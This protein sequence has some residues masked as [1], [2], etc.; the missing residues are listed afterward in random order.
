M[1]TNILSREH[2]EN[3]DSTEIWDLPENL[4]IMDSEDDSPIDNA[5]HTRCITPI[6]SVASSNKRRSLE[7]S[8]NGGVIVSPFQ[9]QSQ[10]SN[11][12]VRHQSSSSA[13]SSAPGT[14]SQV[15]LM[16]QL[17]ANW[18][19]FEIKS[20]LSRI[21]ELDNCDEDFQ[22]QATP[23]KARSI[24][25]FN[26]GTQT[27][28]G[29]TLGEGNHVCK[30]Q[31]V[32][33]V[34]L[35]EEVTFLDTSQEP[36]AGG[37][38][39]LPHVA[40]H[41]T[42]SKW[43][44]RMQNVRIDSLHDWSTDSAYM[45]IPHYMF[46][47]SGLHKTVVKG[48]D[49]VLFNR[50]ACK[51]QIKF[52]MESVIEI[53]HNGFIRGQPGTGKSTTTFFTVCP[54]RFEYDIVWI[55]MGTDGWVHVVTMQEDIMRK[56]E[57]RGDDFAFC[58]N[59]DVLDDPHRRTRKIILVLDSFN[60]ANDKH[61]QHVCEGEKWRAKDSSNRR[62]IAVSSMAKSARKDCMI[63]RGFEWHGVGSWKLEEYI[64]A[65]Q[66]IEIW[67]SVKGYFAEPRLVVG[68]VSDQEGIIAMTPV[69]LV[70]AKFYYAG[71][72]ARYMFGSTVAEIVLTLTNLIRALSSTTKKN[73]LSGAIHSTKFKH[74]CM[75]FT[76]ASPTDFTLTGFVSQFVARTLG[77]LCR[78]RDIR[79]LGEMCHL[80]PQARGWMFEAFFLA[81]V[82]GSDRI[83]VREL[84]NGRAK[85]Q[86]IWDCP[87]APHERVIGFDP[88]NLERKVPENT[89]LQPNATTHPGY[90][91]VMLLM[92]G[93]V[94]FV[95]TT[96]AQKHDLKM[97]ALADIV[98]RLRQLGY[99]VTDAEIFFVIPDGIRATEFEISHLHS[100]ESF[101]TLFDVKTLDEVK[102]LIKTVVIKF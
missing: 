61:R 101:G 24:L 86:I 17:V 76:C 29:S 39:S 99:T 60:I 84:V 71:V 70:T 93:R 42:R 13:R 2:T 43:L 35:Y 87:H 90:D 54:L 89:W 91:A 65:V 44:Q 6:S 72:S 48:N 8:P 68:A 22:E 40:E 5:P 95:Q 25:M 56:T 85:A 31:Y 46:E 27:P 77:V 53:G 28:D 69:D 14:P 67:E 58:W 11:P 33:P 32:I 97:W 19:S 37:K 41:S 73:T 51:E 55:N 38:W 45:R 23:K 9:S 16:S 78:S 1:S 83:A 50:D 94:R 18:E 74:I 10:K 7:Y 30:V 49:L 75:S 21:L 3:G 96:V 47:G 52:I 20:E 64:A 92:G 12:L 66:N 100:W 80:G 82:A 34:G 26:E 4:Q 15:R 57:I 98:K 62:L 79:E 36:L 59:S 88:Y 102:K 81:R 63:P